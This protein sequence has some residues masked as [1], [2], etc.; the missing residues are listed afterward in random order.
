MSESAAAIDKLRAELVNLGAA[1]AYDVGDEATLSVWIGLV[2]RYR[3]GYFRWRE[4]AVNR[5]HQ[6]NDPVG[7]AVRVARRYAELRE[8]VPPWWDGPAAVQRGDAAEAHP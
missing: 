5:R 7:C 1:E 3:D 8:H 4:G 6:G 2:V